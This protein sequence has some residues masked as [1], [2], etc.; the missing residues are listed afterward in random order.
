MK[1]I[2]LLKKELSEL[3][4]VQMLLGLL[5][6]L[7]I[8]M[9]LGS[10]MDTTIDEAVEKTT[11]YTIRL[12]DRDDTEFT[13]D[14]IKSIEND[15]NKVRLFTD[16]G[17]DYAAILNSNDIKDVV[18]IPKGF[19]EKINKAQKP[20]IITA[21]K[22]TSAATIS[23]INAGSSSAVS[24]IQKYVSEK[25]ASMGGLTEEQYKIVNQPL[26][27][28]ENTVVADNYAEVSSESIMSRIAIQNMMLPIIVFVL[29][30]LT[31]QMLMS[32]VA[33]EKTD[34]TLE[35]L[36]SAPIS[37]GAVIGAKM[38]AAA[39]IALINAAVYMIGFKV[40]MG[41]ATSKISSSAGELISGQVS[42][43]EGMHQL[44]MALGGMDYFLVG[45]QLFFTI[46][47]CLSVSLILGA[48]IND[49]K[50]TQS[51]I[52][53]IM[54]LA[55]IPYMISMIADINSLPTVIRYIVYA[56]P[57]THTFSAIPNL[58]FG[59]TALFTAGLIYQII[60]FI[61]CM[62]FALRLFMSDKLFTI[63]LNFGQKSK[64]KA[65]KRRKSA[66]K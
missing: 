32:A 23:N 61:I 66:E 41:D 62:F 49:T 15:G 12:I 24:L 36:L 46:M 8:F 3:I 17:D 39:I 4:T 22:M 42:V 60:V 7:G 19:T 65:K 1:F 59:R 18:I 20:E 48:L 64:Y 29:I 31:S 37:R 13:Q 25:V 26:T 11:N 21:A 6:S 53:P 47:I 54:M 56:I 10:V 5:V 57:F 34:K 14:M 58:M 55:I 27:V 45:L 2:N 63:S 33:N 50:N 30:I 9:A 43:D 38:L 51:M 40:C 28:R 35:T 52:M 44:G 16:T